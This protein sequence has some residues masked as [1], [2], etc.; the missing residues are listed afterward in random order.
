[1]RCN[2]ATV[3]LRGKIADE[4]SNH[5]WK[6][7]MLRFIYLILRRIALIDNQR[8]LLSPVLF[9]IIIYFEIQLKESKKNTY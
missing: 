4:D 7:L 8:W 6:R 1:M 5:E 9:V 3:V 2:I